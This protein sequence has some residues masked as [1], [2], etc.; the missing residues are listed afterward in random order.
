MKD[1]MIVVKRTIYE[2][3][4][5]EWCCNTLRD[6]VNKNRTIFFDKGDGKFKDVDENLVSFCMYCGSSIGYE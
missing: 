6:L 3:Q 5:D 2:Y 1:E 4:I